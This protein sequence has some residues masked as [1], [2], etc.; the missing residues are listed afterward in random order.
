MRPLLLVPDLPEP[1]DDD[2]VVSWSEIDAWRQC[3]YKWLLSYGERWTGPTT[4][5]P[6]RRGTL[7]HLCMELHYNYVKTTNSVE[8]AIE[9]VTNYLKIASEDDDVVDLIV[10]MYTGYVSRW[11]AEDKDWEI[12]MVEG[13]LELPLA[14]GIRIKCRLDLVVRDNLGRVWLIDHK[15]GRNLPTGR[16]LDL[17]DQ[18]GLYHWL[19]RKA[20]RSVFGIIHN[21]VRTQRNQSPMGM[22]ERFARATTVRIDTELDTLADEI[23]STALDI[24]HARA[25]LAGGA[26]TNMVTPRHPDPERCRWRCDY[27]SPCLLGRKTTHRRTQQMLGDIGWVQDF[28]RH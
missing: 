2:L 11:F 18:F 26:S 17:D 15:T 13:R 21:A 9:A 27:T 4:S 12:L 10:W 7:W 5:L 20:G 1:S 16:E 22:D 14:E 8:K 23:R 25:E 28:T 19:L 3:P 24:A 6:L